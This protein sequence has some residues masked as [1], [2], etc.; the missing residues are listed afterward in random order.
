VKRFWKAV[1]EP[2]LAAVKPTVLVEVGCER[3]DNTRNLAQFCTQHRCDLH[4]IDPAPALDPAELAHWLSQKDFGFV[5]HQARSLE[6]LPTLARVDVAL[7]D[8]DHN[9]YSVFHELKALEEVALTG[10]G[11]APLILL[12][13]VGWPYGRRDMYH[14]PQAVPESYRQPFGQEGIH[15]RLQGQTGEQGLNVGVNHAAREGGP[16]NG[17][18]TAVEDYLATSE[19]DYTFTVVPVFH[20]L[21][22]LCPTALSAWNDPLAALLRNLPGQLLEGGLLEA[23]EQDRIELAIDRAEV[24]RVF[25]PSLQALQKQADDEDLLPALEA[26]LD[27]LY[28]SKR[29][30]IGN[31][32]VNGMR[33]LLGLKKGRTIQ[34]TLDQ[35]ITTAKK[36]RQQNQERERLT[37]GASK[38][39]GDNRP[40]V[41][42]LN[43][44]GEQVLLQTRSPAEITRE[45]HQLFY[46]DR[47]TW[48]QTYWLGT[49]VLK[50]PLDLWIYQEI[51][52]QTKPDLIVETGTY[53]GGSALFMASI[54]AQLGH[55]EL[56]TIDVQPLKDRPKHPRLTYLTGSSIDPRVVRS[57][58]RRARTAA[59]VMVV[60]D[61]DHSYQHVLAEMTAYAPFVTQDCFLIVEDTNVN[62]HPVL[63]KYGPGPREAV[64][65]FLLRNADFAIDRQKEKFFM[66]FNPGG[67][68]RRLTMRP[69]WKGD[70]LA[71]ENTSAANPKG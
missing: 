40:G 66:T 6:V 64:E 49:R 21:G 15:P 57:V 5:L 68:L 16:R 70:G 20:G 24:D 45:F 55:G 39:E 7:L 17:V 48:Q 47:Q 69:P 41:R 19:I 14:D 22:I 43:V 27:A 29:W 62:G 18:L 33:K 12:H 71:R 28:H 60:L 34:S 23:V 10:L 61:S 2:L 4:V 11:K 59:R 30:R 35:I 54:C 51:I 56:L 1:L 50:C 42:W 53:A 32:L 36:R 38:F 65:T 31:A 44:A 58:E 9:W 46:G 8:G 3:G 37:P 13:D 26:A 25:R 67:Y 52:S 63:E